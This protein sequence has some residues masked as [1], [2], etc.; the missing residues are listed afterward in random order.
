MDQVCAGVSAI[1]VARLEE[2]SRRV[3]TA[4]RGVKLEENRSPEHRLIPKKQSTHR[5]QI[6]RE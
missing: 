3:A 4:M 5:F 2:S 6:K 1:Q